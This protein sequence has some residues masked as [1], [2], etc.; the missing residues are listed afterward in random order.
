MI[1]LELVEYIFSFLTVREATQIM[2]VCDAFH[3]VG[4]RKLQTTLA[5]YINNSNQIQSLSH[6]RYI[7]ARPLVDR[8]NDLYGVLSD[9]ENYVRGE[10]WN[11]SSHGQNAI[12]EWP[13]KRATYATGYLPSTLTDVANWPGTHFTTTQ[14][15]L[16]RNIR[17]ESFDL[18]YNLQYTEFNQLKRYKV[19]VDVLDLLTA[20]RQLIDWLRANR[21][22]FLTLPNGINL[23]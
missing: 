1:P 18:G 20:I 16:I 12:R 17:N 14:R 9:L 23:F 8:L 3:Y 7:L 10:E 5:P 2:R 11:M 6:A 13:S 21:R 15:A 19:D 22:R 4:R